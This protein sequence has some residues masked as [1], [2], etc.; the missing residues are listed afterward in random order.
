MQAIRKE[1]VLLSVTTRRKL[2]GIVLSETD[3][4]KT[5]TGRSHS[6]VESKIGQLIKAEDR[7]C[8]ELRW[9]EAQLKGRRLAP[10]EESTLRLCARH[11]DSRELCLW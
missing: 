3:Q 10:H 4:I 2:K 9:G 1:E 5:N 8:L 11:G 6:C 7:A